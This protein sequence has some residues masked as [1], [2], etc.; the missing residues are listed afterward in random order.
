MENHPIPQDITGFKFK[1]IGKMTIKQ[2]IYLGAGVGIAW[3]FIWIAPLPVYVSWPIA[4]VSATL[5]ISF[6]FLPIAGRPLDVMLGNFFSAL[7]SPTKFI[8]KKEGVSLTGGASEGSAIILPGPKT[9]NNNSPYYATFQP[10]QSATQTP[11]P[12]ANVRDQD[13]PLPTTGT[14]QQAMETAGT[15]VHVISEDDEKKKSRE[16]TPSQED[17]LK[18]NEK[19]LDEKEDKIEKELEEEKA[20]EN[21]SGAPQQNTPELEN[22]LQQTI[23]QKEELEKQL[24]LL[25]SKMSSQQK[26]YTPSEA[27]PTK[28]TKNVRSVPKEMKKEVGVGNIP[29]YP[30]LITGIIKDS[31]NN[32]LPNILVEV[33]DLDNNPVRA[34]KTNGLGQFASATPVVNGK[35]Q[36]SFEDTKKTHKFDLVEIEASGGIVMPLEIISV[37]AREELRRELFN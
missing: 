17:T 21:Q 3:L 34:F 9:Q 1:I 16:N 13:A 8:Y 20:N 5:G 14:P 35:Y 25:Q 2:F 23:K 28:Q 6:A 24:L 11:I 31:R 22:M 30:N 29:E 27:T 4:A 10:P 33:N 36:L 18:E 19:K 15:S 7:T 37:D 12:T 32:P 26:A